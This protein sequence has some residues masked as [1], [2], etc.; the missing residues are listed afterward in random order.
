MTSLLNA[1]IIPQLEKRGMEVFPVVR[2]SGNIKSSTIQNPYIFDTIQSISPNLDPE[3]LKRRSLSDFLDSC[4]E[5][6]IRNFHS[7][8]LIF[9]QFEEFF[10]TFT[11]NWHEMQEE[12]FKQLLEALRNNQ[13]LRVILAIQEQFVNELDRFTVPIRSIMSANYKLEP[14]RRE[15]A[16]LAVTSALNHVASPSQLNLNYQKNSMEQEVEEIITDLM[17]MQ[18]EIGDG[19][20]IKVMEEFIDPTLL[21]VACSSWWEQRISYKKENREG[22]TA[23]VT[24]ALGDYYEEAILKATKLSRTSEKA[25]RR[26]CEQKLITSEGKRNLALKGKKFTEGLSNEVLKILEEKYVISSWKRS[27]AI[28]YELTS[29]RLIDAIKQS[30]SIW[31]ARAHISLKNGTD[32]PQVFNPYVEIGGKSGIPTGDVNGQLSKGVI[33]SSDLTGPLFGKNVTDLA[34]LMKNGSAY[35]VVRTQAHETGEIGGPISSENSTK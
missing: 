17:K 11:P 19:T 3:S 2:L 29:D 20:I 25:I 22:A 30:N 28:F 8:V 13:F 34:G 26:W 32:L 33:K 10:T 21:Q 27:G 9:D 15:D 14:L 7:Q 6:E 12:F 5:K 16:L 4:R 31:K 35:V 18:E 24:K 23:L 1:K